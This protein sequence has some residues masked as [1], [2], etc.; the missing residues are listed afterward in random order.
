MNLTALS[1]AFFSSISLLVFK[2]LIFLVLITELLG[3]SGVGLGTARLGS[4]LLLFLPSSLP[5]YKVYLY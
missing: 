1:L 2:L 5:W 3:W 4:F